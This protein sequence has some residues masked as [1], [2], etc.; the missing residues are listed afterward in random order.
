MA[1][2]VVLTY[3]LTAHYASAA[4]AFHGIT[5]IRKLK[6]K[7]YGPAGITKS[8]TMMSFVVFML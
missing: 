1:Y 8:L 5:Y 3:Q 6:S 2:R 7:R 4:A